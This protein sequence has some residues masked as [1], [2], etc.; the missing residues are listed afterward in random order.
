MPPK[1]T[2][3][4]FKRAGSAPKGGK[5]QLDPAGAATKGS[6]R[7]DPAV[8]PRPP[9]WRAWVAN[10]W[11]IV[12]LTL[13]L[14]NVFS[15]TKARPAANPVVDIPYSTFLDQLAGRNVSEVNIQGNGISGSLKTE[16]TYPAASSVA[17]AGA[18]ASPSAAPQPSQTSDRFKTRFPDFG[19]PALLPA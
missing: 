9:R 17:S 12:A 19:D 18:S 16:F 5:S 3:V 2:A 14:W 6:L 15:L 10:P 4:R 13:T 7:N 11:L 8:T 1:H